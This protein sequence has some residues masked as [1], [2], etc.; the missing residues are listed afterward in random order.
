MADRIGPTHETLRMPFGAASLNDTDRRI[1]SIAL[2][3]M[4]ALA[5]DPIYDLCDTAILGH[6]GRDQLAGAAT[7]GSILL[8]CSSV[9]IFLMF[10]TTAAVARSI[11][12]SREAD[13]DRYAVQVMWLAAAIGLALT[14]V[15]APSGSTLISWFGARG[16]V[17]HNALTYFRIS[18]VGIPAFLLT[19]A[20]AGVLRGRQNT[21][22]VLALSV[23]GVSV[24]L[25]LEIVLIYGFGLGVGASAA[26]TVIARWL[27]A[28]CYLAGTVRRARSAGVSLA[29][30]PD[31][32]SEIGVEGSPLVIRTIAL[33]G[34][35]SVGVAAAGRVGGVELAA[36]AIAF[37][38]WSFLAYIAD[39]LE[40]AGQALIG[41]ELGRH[42]RT[43][44]RTVGRRIL[45]WAAGLGLVAA[46]I[47]ALAAPWVGHLFTADDAVIEAATLS[48]WFV[49][50]TQPLNA[51]TFSLDGILVGAGDQ[52]FLAV[53]M[54]GASVVYIGAVAVI[55]SLDGGLAGLWMAQVLFMACRL[56]A[57]RWR[58]AG[59][60]WGTPAA[61]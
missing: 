40:T 41:Y 56:V 51:V 34:A 3:A 6:L 49:A 43:A 54:V 11:G 30:R 12:A 10:T 4:A 8:T 55:R 39:G 19:M 5:A 50:A 14:A 28:G 38:I 21:R 17:R 61:A 29:P 45:R 47:A 46:A 31:Q 2:P 58:F 25:V 26:G 33:R 35:L 1:L 36:Y 32:I 18:L 52:R 53:S 15:L 37:Q 42:D 20:G 9:F 24:N 48:L 44:A 23:V 60:R 7:A 59:D 27:V 16:A 57:L 22:G 13:A